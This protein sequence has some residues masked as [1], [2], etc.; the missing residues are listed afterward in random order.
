MTY[1]NLTTTTTT[2]NDMEPRH[3]VNVNDKEFFQGLFFLTTA[4]SVCY[5]MVFLTEYS[6]Y[7][8]LH[9]TL[10]LLFSIILGQFVNKLK[11]V[12]KVITDK[13]SVNKFIIPA[14]LQVR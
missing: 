2:T 12:T 3:Y 9:Q 1:A 14:F 7:P 4:I 13:L 10:I 5:I 8:M 11:Q 6:K